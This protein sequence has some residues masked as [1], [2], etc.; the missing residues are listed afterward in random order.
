MLDEK[1][2]EF[3]RSTEDAVDLPALD[4]LLRRGVALRRRRRAAVA[5]LA[6][7]VLFAVAAVG[8]RGAPPDDPRP[9][10]DPRNDS[11]MWPGGVRAPEIPA[12]TYEIL[13]GTDRQLASAFVT[14]PDGWRAMY[15]PARSVGKH[16]FMSLLVLD[17]TFVAQQACVP[18][19]DTME[20]VGDAPEGLVR[21]LAR[22]PR[23]E[24][25]S[26]PAPDERFGLPAT[27]LSLR[28]TGSLRC[29]GLRGLPM[30]WTEELGLIVAEPARFGADPRLD[31][32]VVDLDGEAVLV[33][34]STSAVVPQWARDQLAGV[35]DSLEFVVD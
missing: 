5:A 35:V 12:G 16:G 27:H 19:P 11:S 6:A 1:L 30:I 8:S 24:V 13:L 21:A 10:E 3:A 32:W 34:A 31:L 18:R 22:I 2:R 15:G 33:A 28:A 26:G 9:V 4:D 7:A 17:V 20:P 29:P 14:V 23:S 25:V